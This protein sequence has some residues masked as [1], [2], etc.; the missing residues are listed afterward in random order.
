MTGQRRGRLVPFM[1]SPPNKSVALAEQVVRLRAIH[2]R[3]GRH[4]K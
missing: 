1:E 3:R 2:S 4:S